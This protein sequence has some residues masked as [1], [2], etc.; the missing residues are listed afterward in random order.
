MTPPNFF[1][2]QQEP[3]VNF[4]YEIDEKNNYYLTNVEG[5]RQNG[6]DVDIDLIKN[7]YTKKRIPMRVDKDPIGKK[8]KSFGFVNIPTEADIVAR[9]KYVVEAIVKIATQDGKWGFAFEGANVWQKENFS[10]ALTL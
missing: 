3:D 2:F 7:S 1:F 6:D 10:R 5:Q 8:L 4:Y 9:F